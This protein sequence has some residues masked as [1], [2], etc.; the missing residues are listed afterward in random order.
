MSERPQLRLLP[1]IKPAKFRRGAPFVFANE[2]VMDRRTRNIEAGTIGTLVDDERNPLAAIAVNPDSK[3][4]GRILD[5]D[6]DAEITSDWLKARLGA[7]L[8]MREALYDAPFYRLCHGEGDGLS[9]LVVDR[10]GDVLSIQPNAAWTQSHLPVIIEVLEGL[11]KAKV[12]YKNASSRSRKLEGLDETS[13]FL[14]GTQ[15]G[16][17]EV[18]MNGALYLADIAQGQKTGLFLD[19]RENHAFA[20]RLAKGQQ[21]LDVFCNVGGFGLAALAAG[22]ERCLAID[23][24]FPA[25]ELAAQAAERMGVID[26]FET[27]KS[28]AVKA[29]RAM[30]EEETRYG[31]VICDPPAFAPHAQALHS[32]LRGYEN[33]ALTAA[34]LVTSGGFLVLCSCSQ[35]ADLD[36]FRN[37]CL[38]G[39]G[40][41]GRQASLIHTGGP[42]PDHPTHPQLAAQTYLKS[43]FFKLY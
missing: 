18:P 30:A 41:A 8:A 16:P 20:A 7:A 2:L 22:A 28:D 38:T 25:L 14:K 27:R 43:L 21:V 19:Q 37:A 34:R 15:E 11:T 5:L 36:S 35:A 23:G 12:I 1:K 24:S 26:Q 9:G 17:V 31:L 29:M 10:Y 32:G 33:V 3:I 13:E 6:P 42:G 39:I 40:K 4:A